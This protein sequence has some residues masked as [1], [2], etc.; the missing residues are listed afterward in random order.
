[1]ADP[2]ADRASRLLARLTDAT[3][4][5]PLDPPAGLGDPREKLP[6]VADAPPPPGSRQR[7]RGAR[8]GRVRGGASRAAGGRGDRH[9]AARRAP[10][11]ARDADADVRHARR[12][13]G[14]R[15]RAARAVLARV[16]GRRDVR[17]RAALPAREPVGAP[18]AAA[19]GGP[20]HLPAD[21]AARRA[22]CS[23]TTASR[24]SVVRAFVAEA[25]ATGID[26][27]RIFDALNDIDGMRAAI[28]AALETPALIEGALC[29]TGDLHDPAERV[30]HAR[31][32]PAPRRALDRRRRA[33]A[34][35]QGHGR[36]AA[37]ARRGHADRGAARALRRAGAPAHPRHRGRVARDLPRRRRGR[38][39]TPIDGAAA[40]LAGM[41]SQPSLSAIVAA[42]AGGERDAGAL[43][44]RAARA[45]A[46]LGGGARRSTRRSSPGWPR[47]PAASTATRS[48]AASSPTCASR[49]PRSA[50]AIASRR[51]RRP[52]SAPTRC[53]ATSSRS[54]RRARSS[55]TSRSTPSRPAST[56]TS[57]SASPTASTCPTRVL[58]F[59]RG[60]LGQPPN[61]LPQP[62]TDRALEGPARPPPEPRRS[63]RDDAARARRSPAA[64][65]QDAL[66]RDR[67]SPAPTRTTTPPASATATSRCSRPPRSSTA[68][69][70]TR[71]CRS[72]SPPACA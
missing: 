16:L 45:R 29:Y 51:S 36:P 25:V 9:D 35:D 43:A 19:R 46:L 3:V 49:P 41:T 38:A 58:D 53:S 10:V 59:L 4:N 56:S 65:R 6:P 24:N 12:G 66:A 67:S 44:R 50:S 15:A 26:V 55:A 20:E 37:R 1:M 31:L 13:A 69:A 57:S 60:G 72:T 21:A 61:G 47:R 7:L 28:E 11:A 54:R 17:R 27:F 62:F 8:S 23:P 33:R 63:T 70:K 30:V 68:C 64:A 42:L 22:T 71:R 32:L 18:R 40:P 52:T 14:D 39:S 34:R 48:P 2:G 5:R